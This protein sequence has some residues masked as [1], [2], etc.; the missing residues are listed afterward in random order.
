MIIN[1]PLK[2]IIPNPW[3]TRTTDPDPLYIKELALD[4]AKNGLLQVPAGRAI[5][6]GNPIEIHFPIDQ[7]YL[8]NKLEDPT[9]SIQLAFGHNRLAA[10]RWLNDLSEHSNLGDFS[11]MPVDL[12]N[13]TD[14]QMAEVAWSENEKRR[15]V[16][17]IERAKAIQ[18][19]MADFGWSLP[20][21]AERLGLARPTVSNILRL[22]K[23]P[24][25]IQ[26]AVNAGTI[27]ARVASALLPLYDLPEHTLKQAELSYYKRP[28]A[29]IHD[30]FEGASSDHI[31]QAVDY[32]YREHTR[33]LDKA[34]FG[35]H[36]VYPENTTVDDYTVY[37]GLCDT[38]DRRLKHDGNICLDIECYRAKEQLYIRNYLYTAAA[39]S[40]IEVSDPNK[41]GNVTIFPQWRRD[42]VETIKTTHC[43]NLCLVWS[44]SELD[45]DDPRSI[46]GH[47]HAMIACDKRNNSCTCLK[48]L[49]LA[50]KTPAIKVPA[51][52]DPEDQ[53]QFENTSDPTP[54]RAQT[55][56]EL[57]DLTR[58][59]RR[60]KQDA[61]KQ[62]TIL[63]QELHDLAVKWFKN[64][65][66]GALHIL[67]N[68]NPF[69]FDL[70]QVY[71]RAAVDFVHI[72]FN[73]R[74]WDSIEKMYDQVNQWL[75]KA[76]LPLIQK[77]R[78]LAQIFASD[79]DL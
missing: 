46:P 16:T 38:C 9:Y 6:F 24:E 19:R 64:G 43:E 36:T 53:D 22:L 30:A 34:I 71:E 75:E 49:E 56:S 45:K 35:Q 5:G 60:S 59:A 25:Q 58:Q 44:T 7:V 73:G 23:L 72:L 40:G 8:I 28:S 39:A 61:A 21:I 12:L 63:E 79:D 3:Q 1:V 13:L 20:E 74:D 32:I 11:H 54:V 55:A 37:C 29:I 4:I 51:D 50:P 41:G 67:V 26:Q 15:D 77:E 52:P 66:P 14:E 31:R 2:R 70:D 78:T 68:R 27:S 62:K 33:P 57:E 65:E 69:V 42:T 10:Y 17:P 48:G 47:P 18:K 76:N